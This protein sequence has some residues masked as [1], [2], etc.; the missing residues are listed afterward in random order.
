[1]LH[2][3][4]TTI[5]PVWLAM[6]ISD[7]DDKHTSPD[8][9]KFFIQYWEPCARKSGV[10]PTQAYANCWKGFWTVNE[11]YPQVWENADAIIWSWRPNKLG[12]FIRMKKLQRHSLKAKSCLRV[13]G[14]IALDRDELV[15]ASDE[16]WIYVEQLW[17][18]VL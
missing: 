1:M 14:V 6:A 3:H 9:K 11:K 12:P 4:D 17:I 13:H 7:I 16:E 5:Y 15:G 2:P 18:L 10:T 8:Y